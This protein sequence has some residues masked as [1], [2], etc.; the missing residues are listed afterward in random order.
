MLLI[1]KE[2]FTRAVLSFSSPRCAIIARLNVIYTKF[3]RAMIRQP[4][5]IWRMWPCTRAIALH[6]Q[7]GLYYEVPWFYQDFKSENLFFKSALSSSS[8]NTGSVTR[9]HVKYSQMRNET[10]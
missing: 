2:Y 9:G 3:R 5:K 4:N 6:S 8:E 1:C 7:P 10:P